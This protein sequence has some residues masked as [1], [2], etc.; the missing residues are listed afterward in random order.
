MFDLVEFGCS[1][2]QINTA[3]SDVRNKN[4]PFSAFLPSQNSLF[5][6]AHSIFS[7]SRES[8]SFAKT[9]C[10]I[11]LLYV[12]LGFLTILETFGQPGLE[13]QINGAWRPVPPSPNLL[14]VNI[15]EQLG[16]RSRQLK[17]SASKY[18]PFLQNGFDQLF[19]YRGIDRYL[20]YVTNSCSSE[21]FRE[22]RLVQYP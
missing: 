2:R 13:L 11:E 12:A 4:T 22:E 8:S 5:P 18:R 19:V 7:S 15:G 9:V 16:Q 21:P 3:S 17:K 10:K 20:Y 1:Q 6:S 14:I